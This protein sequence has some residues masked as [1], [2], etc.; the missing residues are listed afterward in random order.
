M[1]I[2]T[3]YYFYNYSISSSEDLSNSQI[4]NIGNT[5]VNEAESLFALGP[6]SKTTLSLSFPPGLENAYIADDK[7]LVLNLSNDRGQLAFLSD[8][9]LAGIYYNDTSTPCTDICFSPG[10]KRVIL[11]AYQTNVSVIIK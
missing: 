5:I 9:P 8:A 11:L 2:P 6:P 3:V 1:L 7:E 10:A 4:Y